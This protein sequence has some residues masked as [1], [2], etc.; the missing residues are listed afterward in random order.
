MLYP[1]GATLT[2]GPFRLTNLTRGA[3][4]ASEAYLAESRSERRRGL[5][6]SDPLAPGE[7]L[8]LRPCR[9]V[10]TFGMR[11]PIEVAFVD[12]SSVVLAVLR[13]RPGR[14][15]RVAWRAAATVELPA[16]TLERTITLPGDVL[17]LVI[18]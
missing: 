17:D 5:L 9:Q 11:F 6:G 4:L 16:G 15:S 8:V 1:Q 18:T 10:H 13:M 14:L 12:G 3:V 7:A 2:A